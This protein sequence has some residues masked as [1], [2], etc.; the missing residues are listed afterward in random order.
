MKITIPSKSFER[1]M[2]SAKNIID[3]RNSREEL[4]YVK[5]ALLRDELRAV[6]C[7]GYEAISIKIGQY[8]TIGAPS[9]EIKIPLMQYK[10]SDLLFVE[11]D[12]EEDMVKISEYESI[13]DK[14]RVLRT[15]YYNNV[16]KKYPESIDQVLIPKGSNEK[17]TVNAVNLIKALKAISP[18]CDNSVHRPV[19]IWVEGHNLF[20]ENNAD[21]RCLVLGLRNFEN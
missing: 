5:F 7:D 13:K 15:W 8:T 12:Q 14:R 11:I 17:F 10:G 2:K 6:A 18:F 9:E 1:L 20:I 21:T 19:R 16:D 3:T 4:Q